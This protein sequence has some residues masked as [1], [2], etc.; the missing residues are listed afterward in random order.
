MS[1]CHEDDI[2]SIESSYSRE[3]IHH[4]ETQISKQKSIIYSLSHAVQRLVDALESKEKELEQIAQVRDRIDIDL[5][6]QVLDLMIENAELKHRLVDLNVESSA[7]SCHTAKTP[8]TRTPL[9]S[10][11][12]SFFET[13]S[14][15]QENS[16]MDGNNDTS[17]P[18]MNKIEDVATGKRLTA[19]KW[20]LRLPKPPSTKWVRREY[21]KSTGRSVFTGFKKSLLFFKKRQCPKQI[22][23]SNMSVFDDIISDIISV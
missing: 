6:S 20:L 5:E 23:V 16:S 9:T 14:V 12:F 18:I 21:E 3:R 8:A 17:S 7:L 2:S 4:S 19:K 15:S 11:E 13:D 22:M 1:F 10:D